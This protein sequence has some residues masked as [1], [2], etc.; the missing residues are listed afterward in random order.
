MQNLRNSRRIDS[1]ID[2]SDNIDIPKKMSNYSNRRFNKL[3]MYRHRAISIKDTTRVYYYGKRYRP[4]K[5]SVY[6]NHN[7]TGKGRMLM[8][9]YYCSYSFTHLID[10]LIYGVEYDDQN[11]D[12]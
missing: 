2:I 7:S 5:L 8:S 1:L 12:V 6:S 4:N 9:L 10:D 11:Y 3:K